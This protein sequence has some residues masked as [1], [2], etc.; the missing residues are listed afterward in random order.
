MTEKPESI[1]VLY[2][3]LPLADGEEEDRLI[4]V[5]SSKERAMQ[6]QTSLRDQPIFRDAPDGFCIDQCALGKDCWTGGYVTVL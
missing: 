1:Y 6:K 4:G 3:M 2:H 5:Y